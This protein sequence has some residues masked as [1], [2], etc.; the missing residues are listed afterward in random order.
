MDKKEI[1]N[2]STKARSVARHLSRNENYVLALV[3]VALA[4][5]FAVPTKGFTITPGNVSN[6]ILLSSIRGVATIGQVFVIL[7]AGIDLAVGGIAALTSVVGGLLISGTTGPPLAG[8]A[9]MILLG[10]AIGSSSGLI[11]SRLRLPPFIV[12]LAIWTIVK[13]M[14]LYV[15]KGY[16]IG[17]F[18][19][20]MRFFGQGTIGPVPVPIIIFVVMAV[21]AYLVLAYTSFGRAIYA[22][23]GNPMSAWLSGINVQSTLFWVYVISGAS[24]ALAGT[25]LM[26]RSMA[27]T[28]YGASGLELDAI[29]AS[30]IGGLSLAGGKGNIIGA[31]I[32]VIIIGVI[33]NGMNV[34]QLNP[35]LYDVVK[36][37][38][39]YA[40]VT[41]DSLRRSKG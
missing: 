2:G 22:S 26:S 28:V 11:V 1:Q 29:A 21:A 23:G 30:V 5:A 18:P 32:G 9:V 17:N 14:A 24:G 25:M 33:N 39:I 20:E 27:A 36:G 3:L 34:M 40:A 35:A 12:T 4:T 38:I 13:G 41:V 10:M 31:V 19:P 15:S 7:T 16:T 6:I 8:V 37:G